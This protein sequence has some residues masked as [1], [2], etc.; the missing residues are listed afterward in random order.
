MRILSSFSS[1]AYGKANIVK[2]DKLQIPRKT[3]QYVAH[4]FEQQS[5]QTGCR[6]LGKTLQYVADSPEQQHI[7]AAPYRLGPIILS[8]LKWASQTTNSYARRRQKDAQNLLDIWPGEKNMDAGIPLHE[9]IYYTL[10]ALRC[11]P[12][13]STAHILYL[14]TNS[15]IS[16]SANQQNEIP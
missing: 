1:W 5:S 7:T 11:S 12:C 13:I 15:G 4:S 8:L 16:K 10:R 14:Q 3:I 2:S 6:N 9:H